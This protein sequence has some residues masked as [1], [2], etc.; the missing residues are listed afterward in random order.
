MTTQTKMDQGRT[1]LRLVR[2]E[3]D[4]NAKREYLVEK[5]FTEK[6][7]EE[8]FE[9]ERRERAEGIPLFA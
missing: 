1:W 3:D 2:A 6:Q 4:T 9:W 8:L 5:G 7:L